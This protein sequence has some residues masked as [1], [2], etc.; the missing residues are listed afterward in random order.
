MAGKGL[1]AATLAALALVPA[2]AARPA[3]PP[4]GLVWAPGLEL[5]YT[6]TIRDGAGAVVAQRHREGLPAG[7]PFGTASTADSGLAFATLVDPGSDLVAAKARPRRLAACC[8]SSGSD[9]VTFTLTKK[10]LLGNVAW[11][12]YQTDHW[13]WSYPRIT[14]LT[15]GSDFADV[16]GQQSVNYSDH[17]YGWY[18]TWSGSTVGGHYAHRDGSISNCIFR[19]GCISTSYPYVDMWLNGNGAWT[20]SGGGN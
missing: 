5:S 11:R 9:T 12:Y 18:Y 16:D 4:P 8:S 14:C 15:V 20:A 7:K 1:A 3:A 10:T 17:G 19:W 13:C 2:A 6:E